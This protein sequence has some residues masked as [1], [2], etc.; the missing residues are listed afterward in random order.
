MVSSP[1][2][3]YVTPMPFPQMLQK[4]KQDKKF[5]NFPSVPKKLHINIPFIDAKLQISSYSRF[6]KDKLTMKRKLSEFETIAL[7]EE[8][9]ARMQNKL[10]P[11]L[12]DRGL[13]FYLF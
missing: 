2:K 1:A 9:S 6:L 12:K 4:N 11:E 8:S 10:P 13:L 3:T 5:E 7:T